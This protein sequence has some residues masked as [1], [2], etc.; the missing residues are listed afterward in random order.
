MII[1]DDW[2]FWSLSFEHLR[3][4]IGHNRPTFVDQR[5]VVTTVLLVIVLVVVFP[6]TDFFLPLEEETGNLKIPFPIKDRQRFRVL[7]LRKRPY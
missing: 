6:P 7:P 2:R 5:Q 4:E 1:L 3:T